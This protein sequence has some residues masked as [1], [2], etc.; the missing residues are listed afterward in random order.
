MICWEIN[1]R[2]HGRHYFTTILTDSNDA[3]S[4]YD[5]LCVR[6]PKEYGFKVDMYQK[7]RNNFVCNESHLDLM[8]KKGG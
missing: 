8:R 5:D 3:I 6:F 1:V 7:E 2:K 4:V